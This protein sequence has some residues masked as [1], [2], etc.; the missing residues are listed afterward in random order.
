M[1][2]RIA[3]HHCTAETPIRFFLHKFRPHRIRQDVKAHTGKRS[4]L[5]LFLAQHMVMR[6]RLEF[7]LALWLR[8]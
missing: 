5:A 2:I 3:R 8:S 7:P 4:L 1:Q 6:L